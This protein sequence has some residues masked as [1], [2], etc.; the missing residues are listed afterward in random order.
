MLETTLQTVC[1]GITIASQV[2][3]AI[4]LLQKDNFDGL[5]VNRL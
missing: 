5:H 2:I 1:K 3:Q 4:E